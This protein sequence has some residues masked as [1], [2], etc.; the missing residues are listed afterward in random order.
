MLIPD[1][2]DHVILSLSNPLPQR[3]EEFSDWYVNSHIP[4]ILDLPGAISGCLFQAIIDDASWKYLSVFQLASGGVEAFLRESRSRLEGGKIVLCDALDIASTKLLVSA[5]TASLPIMNFDTIILLGFSA[6]Q[7]EQFMQTLDAAPTIAAIERL[8]I[9]PELSS[10]VRNWRSV[11]LAEPLESSEPGISA[12][13]EMIDITTSRSG[14]AL[15]AERIP[16]RR[17]FPAPS[18]GLE[19]L[20]AAR[21]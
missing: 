5:R 8:M 9:R 18:S 7:D 11:A 19:Q 17:L 13:L 20:D 2:S 10:N 3:D 1:A 12:A 15:R 4:D 16:F 21:F 6:N 14:R